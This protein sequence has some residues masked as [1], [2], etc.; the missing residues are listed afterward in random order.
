[1]CV[2]GSAIDNAVGLSWDLSVTAGQHV[3]RSH[4][5]SFSSSNGVG[6][7]LTYVALGDSFS[8]GEGAGAYDISSGDPWCHRSVLAYPPTIQR[9]IQATSF[10][11]FACSGAVINDISNVFHT[12]QHPLELSDQL[13]AAK[14]FTND[15]DFVTIGVGGNDIGFADIVKSC[16]AID[17]CDRHYGT[18]DLRSQLYLRLWSLY[19][20]VKASF[21]S[22]T[23]VT[24]TYPK[25]FPDPDHQ[26]TDCLKDA[27]SDLAAG[28]NNIGSTSA[29]SYAYT[30]AAFLPWGLGGFATSRGLDA[31]ELRWI[32][33][34]TSELNQV[35]KDA[36]SAAGINVA[37]VENAFAGHEL[38]TSEPAANAFVVSAGTTSVTGTFVAASGPMQSI[39]E[40]FHPNS[41][42]QKF[43]ADAITP[44]VGA[45]NPPAAGPTSIVGGSGSLAVLPLPWLGDASIGSGS[46]VAQFLQPG[47]NLSLQGG[48]FQ[49]GG[50]VSV[51]FH[52]ASVPLGDLVADDTG[53]VNGVV[54]IPPDAATGVHKIELV[55]PV[56]DG[57]RG[58]SEAPVFVGVPTDFTYTAVTPERL[59]DTRTGVGAPTGKAAG[60]ATVELQVTGAGATNVPG[61]ASA[62]VLNITATEP[63]GP[64]YVTVWPCGQP[65][66]LA[67]N[68]NYTAGDS[69][70]N[71]V[72]AKLGTDGKVCLYTQTTTHL[73]AD[74]NG[75][76]PAGAI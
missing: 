38:C 4:I 58:T 52:S 37:D 25:Y 72:I 67:S 45:G 62:V 27:A 26:S 49:P 69:I 66:P 63:D 40:S 64:G 13:A 70:P 29:F 10:R 50:S 68:L 65:Q 6:G 33:T 43:Y 23:V 18:L 2:C 24:S 60:G 28:F 74:I 5:T 73:I 47:S 17:R 34:E 16:I 1:V 44:Y 48:G 51:V 46:N 11:S 75:W 76:Y 19:Q 59:L 30:I 57:L 61:G 54:T 15:A 39:Q 42:G 9:R 36:A 71:V 21:P 41:L 55:G 14:S 3:M 53:V 20:G 32:R 31:S 22:A 35:I 56:A 12:P 7:A 8:A